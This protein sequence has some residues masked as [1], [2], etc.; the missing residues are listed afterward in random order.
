MKIFTDVPANVPAEVATIV[1]LIEFAVN[2]NTDDLIKSPT[3]FPLVVRQLETFWAIH[4]AN[5]TPDDIA[6][7]VFVGKAFND[8][9]N[10]EFDYG[11][12]YRYQNENLCPI[13]TMVE[14]DEEMVEHWL[15]YYQDI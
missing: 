10:E 12:Y 6:D 14:Y 7:T 15:Y 9:F 11:W 8:E 5:R 1:R 3:E 4:P 2:A 13:C